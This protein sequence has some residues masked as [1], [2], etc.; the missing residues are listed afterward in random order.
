VLFYEENI[1]ENNDDNGGFLDYGNSIH[2]FLKN[3]YMGHNQFSKENLGEL[4]LDEDKEIHG[5]CGYIR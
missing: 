1:H 4:L 3:Y 2:E 5:R